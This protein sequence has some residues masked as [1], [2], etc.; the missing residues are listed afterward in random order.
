MGGRP[1]PLQG[2]AALDL[3]ALALGHLAA[4]ERHGGPGAGDPRAAHERAPPLPGL[5]ASYWPSQLV[6][7]KEEPI[8]RI[9]FHHFR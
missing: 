8:S 6:Y 9:F 4:A 1:L 5:S 7:S 2:A 3:G